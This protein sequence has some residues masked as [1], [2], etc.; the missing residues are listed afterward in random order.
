[1]DSKV[2]EQNGREIRGVRV[3]ARIEM[4]DSMSAQEL[5]RMSSPL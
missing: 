4:A 5:D 3:E 1:M 2:I